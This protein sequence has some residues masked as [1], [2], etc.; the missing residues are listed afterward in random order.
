[1]LHIVYGN[2]RESKLKTIFSWLW[3]RKDRDAFLVMDI[4]THSFEDYSCSVSSAESIP[5][6]FPGNCKYLFLFSADLYKINVLQSLFAHRNRL[7]HVYVSM[8]HGPEAR[9]IHNQFDVMDE[10]IHTSS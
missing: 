7:E 9:Y 6:G 3:S 8:S 2:C 4:S 1:M 5:R 10:V